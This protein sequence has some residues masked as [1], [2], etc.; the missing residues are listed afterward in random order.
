MTAFMASGIKLRLGSY[1][2]RIWRD[3]AEWGSALGGSCYFFPWHPVF[4]R[5]KK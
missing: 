1:H 3:G 5:F 4:G 2:L